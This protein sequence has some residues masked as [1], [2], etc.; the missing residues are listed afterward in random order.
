M[1]SSTNTKQEQPLPDWM[2]Y[3]EDFEFHDDIW[4]SDDERIRLLKWIIDNKLSIGEKEIFLLYTHNNSNYHKTAKILGCS[5]TTARNKII[6]IR[7]KIL[8]FYESTHEGHLD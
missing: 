3:K 2:P 1:M 7:K 5:V 6:Q 8:R 4:D